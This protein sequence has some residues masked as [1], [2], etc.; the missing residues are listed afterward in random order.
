MASR[1]PREFSGRVRQQ[2]IGYLK[3]SR[4][5]QIHKLRLRGPF[6]PRPL[7]G[8]Q[9][10]TPPKGRRLAQGQLNRASGTDAPCGYAADSPG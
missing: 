8:V 10:R 2:G 4:S 5:K 9:S 6:T 7:A 3:R 1:R